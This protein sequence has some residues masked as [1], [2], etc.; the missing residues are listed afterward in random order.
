VK[1]ITP[2]Q[3]AKELKVK[4]DKIHAWIHSGQLTAINVAEE[5]TGR[6]RWRITQEAID[7]FLLSR[8]SHKPAPA[9]QRR[10]RRKSLPL[11]TKYF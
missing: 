4:V 11:V 2:P 10:T 3:L 5:P 7:Q 8:Q 1:T 6:P 9:P